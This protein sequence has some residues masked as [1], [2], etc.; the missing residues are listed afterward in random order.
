MKFPIQVVAL[1]NVTV[2]RL[3][4]LYGSNLKVSL[5][6]Y[7]QYQSS[8]SS[9]VP[10]SLTELIRQPK[11]GDLQYAGTSSRDPTEFSG[12]L[13]T[14]RTTAVQSSPSVGLRSVPSGSPETPSIFPLGQPL[15]SPLDLA[16]RLIREQRQQISELQAQVQGYRQHCF[17][18]R[19]KAA[20]FKALHAQ[21]QVL[22]EQTMTSLVHL[23]HQDPR[24]GPTSGTMPS[25][26]ASAVCR[27]LP[28][29]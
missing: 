28:P 15:E 24:Q 17:G 25:N 19:T 16:G 14:I 22:L 23:Q 7:L 13:L 8:F 6:M 21:Q 11:R 29:L 1:Y 18:Y 3:Q 5:S 9:S 27:L 20:T 10:P 26:P 2:L 12:R 4:I